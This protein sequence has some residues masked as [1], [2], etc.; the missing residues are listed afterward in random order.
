M[1]AQIP[2]CPTISCASWVATVS[3]SVHG[4]FT[5]EYR[6]LT[7]LTFNLRGKFGFGVGFKKSIIP[8]FLA[9]LRL[10]QNALVVQPFK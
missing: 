2:S 5:L 3:S 4:S 1:E 9:L 7:L 6:T 10:F 8:A